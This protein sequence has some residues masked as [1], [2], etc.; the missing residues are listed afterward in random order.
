MKVKKGH[1]ETFKCSFT[2]EDFDRFADLTGDNNPIHVD[3]EFSARTHFGQPVAHGMLLYS[4][5]CRVLSTQYPGPGI[6]QI[7]QDMM[8]Q[9]PTY[10]QT[11]ITIK[12]EVIDFQSALQ[13]A[14]LSTVIG[15]PDGK[16]A[17]NGSTTVHLPGWKGGFPGIDAGMA[18]AG[19]SEAQSLKRLQVGQ[20]A[21]AKKKFNAEDLSEY[22]A[23]TKDTNPL[24]ND[25]V[26]ARQQGFKD[27]IIP[28]PLLSGMF[29]DLLGTKLPG[30]GTNWLKQKLHFP[31]PAYMGDE[32]TARV[33]I[34][35][36]RP[37]KNLV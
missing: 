18:A 12:L 28:G 21:A 19:D 16:L 25:A 22:A 27:C 13:L 30:R 34:I 10:T 17:C 23:L 24:F 14:E 7:K 20:S 9:N 6:L 33:E 31:A 15:L 36:L 35:R 8:F 32:I 5:I 37:Q 26:F 29:S 2:Q 4:T 3:P 1:I 11:E